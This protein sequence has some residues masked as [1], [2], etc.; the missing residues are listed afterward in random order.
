MNGCKFCEACKFNNCICNQLDEVI[1]NFSD[2][3]G[4]D[5][6]KQERRNRVGRCT[7]ILKINV[8][9]NHILFGRTFNEDLNRIN[10]DPWHILINSLKNYVSY[11]KYQLILICRNR[12]NSIKEI[13][14][15]D[16]NLYNRDYKITKSNIDNFMENYE[17]I[18][19]SYD[20]TIEE[21]QVLFNIFGFTKQPSI[22]CA[23]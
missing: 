18:L 11:N 22:K 8:D 19:S 14:D 7:I 20:I 15:F 2:N 13:Y 3:Y 21:L 4:L 10:K 12:I 16:T 6:V 9:N 17:E 23:S 1:T 5:I